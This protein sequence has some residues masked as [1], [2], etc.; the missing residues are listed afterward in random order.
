MR[1]A[2]FSRVLLLLA[3][4][5]PAGIAPPPGFAAPQPDSIPPPRPRVATI[6][7]ERGDSIWAAYV[8]PWAYDA[9]RYEAVDHRVGYLSIH[10]ISR[11][12][13]ATGMDVTTRTLRGRKPIG[14]LSGAR[15][16]SFG[17]WFGGLAVAPLKYR[18]NRQSRA[19]TIVETALLSRGGERGEPGA[20]AIYYVGLGGM[21]NVSR[22]LAL[23]G[24][25]HFGGEYGDYRAVDVG[26]RA[27][28]YLSDHLSIDATSGTFAASGDNGDTSGLP[29]FAEA[30]LTFADAVALVGRVERAHWKG[31]RLLRT[32][33]TFD[34][35][36]IETSRTS[37]VWRG[38]L[39]LGS[40]P[41]WL[42]VSVLL[43]GT[44]VF[45]QPG[46]QEVY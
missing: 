18:P 1:V 33:W 21:K 43:L 23:G 24:V 19:Y 34:F 9:V 40:S 16:P 45:I 46:S 6:C 12:V 5:V 44:F 29:L 11:V 27:R 10:Q 37:T 28:Y 8:G 35:D 31:H 3:V 17:A 15:A 32:D 22:D 30:A 14:S 7:L 2:R 25:A 26:A 42:S 4:A 36:I 20:G 39:R 41:K 38:G 13:D